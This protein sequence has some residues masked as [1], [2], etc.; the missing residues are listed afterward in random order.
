MKKLV[1]KLVDL[2]QVE[3]SNEVDGATVITKKWV[4]DKEIISGS[5]ELSDMPHK[6]LANAS[7]DFIRHMAA[8]LIEIELIKLNLAEAEVSE[9]LEDVGGLCEDSVRD[10]F[11]DMIDDCTISVDEIDLSINRY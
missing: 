8:R 1:V 10:V 5:R 2:K 9:K 4:E 11:N 3:E 7:Y 6:F